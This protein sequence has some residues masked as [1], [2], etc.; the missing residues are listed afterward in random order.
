MVISSL[1]GYTV[2]KVRMYTYGQPRTGNATYA[3][4]VNGQ[5][6]ENAFRGG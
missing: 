4:L 1:T 2:S 5:F 6:G 3:H